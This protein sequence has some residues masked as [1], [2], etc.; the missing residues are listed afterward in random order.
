MLSM[1]NSIFKIYHSFSASETFGDKHRSSEKTCLAIIYLQQ[2]T[3]FDAENIK[4]TLIVIFCYTQLI[5]KLYGN[6]GEECNNNN[7]YNKNTFLPLPVVWSVAGPVGEDFPDIASNQKC[8][9]YPEQSRTLIGRKYNEWLK[10][11][12]RR[13]FTDD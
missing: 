3:I 4:T 13:Y 1:E 6:S 8:H 9:F 12:E 5:V 7:N 11:Q 10:S 2:T